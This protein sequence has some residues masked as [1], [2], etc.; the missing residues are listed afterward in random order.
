MG[1]PSTRL[2]AL[3][4]A[5]VAVALIAAP[6]ALAEQA[7]P[8]ANAT[9]ANATKREILRSTLCALNRERAHNGLRRLKLNK[10]L[11]R[12]ARRHAHDMGD[13]TTSRTTR[14][15]A[16]RSSTASAPRAT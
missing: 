8:A 1:Y 14:W 10:R 2:F 15:A 12:A 6:T 7:C 16:G 3:V 9:P 4:L 11:S 5:I 13:A